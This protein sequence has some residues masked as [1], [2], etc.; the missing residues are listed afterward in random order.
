[1]LDA[2]VIAD[3]LPVPIAALVMLVIA[4]GFAGWIDAVVGGGGLIQLPALVIGVPQ[5]VSTPNILGTNKIASFAGTLTAS[6]VYLRKI[7]V[8]LVLLI[9]L[10]A[11]AYA[12]STA[13]AAISRYLPREVLTPVVLVAVVGVAIYTFAKPQLGLH[14]EPKHSGGFPVAWRAS[15]IGLIVGLYDGVLGPGTGSFFVILI[16]GMLGFGF[17]QASVN[18]KVANLTTNLAAIVVYGIHGEILLILGLA[19]ALANI[20]GGLIGARM[21]VKNG[22]GFVRKVFLVALAI[23][24]VKL[25]WDT[26][27]QFAA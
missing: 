3:W 1:M 20:A 27:M 16:V 7:K 8:Q 14:H 6:W 23:L 9:P 11:G 12:G 26:W 25:A 17:L 15:A 10:V 2:P 21:A 24:I 18:A 5:D 19:M 22:N 4:A 13:G